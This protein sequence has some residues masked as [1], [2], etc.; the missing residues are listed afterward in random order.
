MKKVDFIIVGQGL[1]GT[2]LSFHL[3]KSG[4]KILIV[5]KFREVTS[6]KVA[7]GLMNPVTGRRF[8]KTWLAD[9]IFPYAE[10]YYKELEEKLGSNF[11]HQMPVYRYLGSVEDQN[12]WMGRS[13]NEAIKPYIGEVNQEKT[14][15]IIN[16]FG[17]VEIRQGGWLNTNEFLSKSREY[18][19][20]NDVLLNESFNYSDIKIDETIVW[21]G[22]EAVKIIFCEGFRAKD[23]P[24]FD[25]LPF[26][27]AKGE[28]LDIKIERVS[29]KVIHNKNGFLMPIKDNHFKLGATFRWNEM[30]ENP[31]ER[32]LIEL[33][34]KLQKFTNLDY[35]II[36]QKGSIRPT[37]KDRRPFIGA[38]NKNDKVL[39]FNGFGSKGVTLTPYFAEHLANYIISQTKL[40]SEVNVSRF[41]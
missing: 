39:I 30:H 16:D 27:F 41:Y 19:L 37:T 2:N 5:D 38:S 28:I 21:K 10:K 22:I 1:A 35:E 32:S 24:Y 40:D 8:A 3:L 23:N 11:Y 34:E 29:N 4:K 13:S 15:G 7:A 36:N 17:V 25:F 9:L 20:E 18:F 12:T 33:K 26:T 6:S 14:E 31:T